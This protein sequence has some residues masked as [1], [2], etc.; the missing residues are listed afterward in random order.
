[1]ELYMGR[2]GG[3]H[4]P[5]SAICSVRFLEGRRVQGMSDELVSVVPSTTHW[6]YSQAPASRWLP[7]KAV[8]VGDERVGVSKGDLPYHFL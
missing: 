7:L 5:Q 2:R 6:P 4:V 1:M 3:D 8:G